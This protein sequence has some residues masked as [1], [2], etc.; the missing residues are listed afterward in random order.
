MEEFLK[1]LHLSEKAISIYLESLGRY[2]LTY[3]ELNSIVPDLSSKEFENS[4]DELVNIGL[5]IPINPQNPEILPYYLTI[6]PFNP[7]MNYIANINAHLES[8]KNQLHQ[9]LANSLKKIFLEN[10]IIE[11]D[12]TFK[13]TQEFKKDFEEE[14][15]IQKQD[16]DD[17]VQGM[18]NLIVIKN[19]LEDL[20]Q[21][22]KGITQTQ[23]ASLVKII[24]KIKSEIKEKLE[25]I[26]LKK[27]ESIVKQTIED[28]FKENLD[29][30]VKDFTT[31]LH[32]MIENEFNNTIESLNNIIDST[33]QF[34]DD[35]KMLLVN[36][37]NN[38]EIKMNKISDLI[39]EKKE[40]L[41]YDLSNFE[42]TIVANFDQI[43]RNS[44]DSVAALN[45][46]INNVMKNYYQAIT[47]SNM[48]QISSFW[49]IN[50]SSRIIE[51]IANLLSNSNK[52]L[53]LILPQLEPYLNVE[54]FRKIT[55]TLKIKLAS[56]E[57]HTN[58]VAKKFKEIKNLE[59]KTLKNENVI[60]L[61][62]DDNCIIIGVI[63][64]NSKDTIN[65]FIGF[66]SNYQPL[67]KLMDPVIKT[68]WELASSDLYQT[69]KS[70][71]IEVT[72]PKE[73]QLIKEAPP[74]S[75]QP[76]TRPQFPTAPEISRPKPSMEVP[77]K[78]EI[79]KTYTP[80]ESKDKIPDL[81]QKLQKQVSFTSTATP[82]AG[83]EAGLLI[84]TAFNSLIQRLSKLKGEDFSE[85]LQQV[86]DLILEKRGFSV[87]LHKL[88]STINKYKLQVAML[89]DNDINQ[90]V[91]EIE[92][93]KKHLL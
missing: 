4:L 5:L 65:N 41:S 52:T 30:L 35:F 63:L 17:I 26:E 53:I 18:E 10:T 23:F 68:T 27:M 93:W 8:I 29:K 83:D 89:N 6:P 11:L 1:Q 50:T 19:V 3:F 80:P 59:Y 62:G 42:K 13:S 81:T 39:K 14:T 7:I 24:T 74:K 15:I 55:N 66:G 9:L 48:A 90:I 64:N 85:Q 37:L 40:T 43:I 46:P 57:A 73:V 67:I 61:K 47:S 34:R 2:P 33:F 36:I 22:I 78:E 69:P 79:M 76:T 72:T 70:I 75:F 20:H 12:T 77:S 31:N 45:N 71:G 60:I 21:T 32:K 91:A 82:K 88:R 49:V 25:S 16:V 51:E 28:V 38:F 56:S 87:T 58:S 86:A 84:N 44:V 92:E 54:K